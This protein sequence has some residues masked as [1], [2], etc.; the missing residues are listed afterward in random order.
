MQMWFGQKPTDQNTDASDRLLNSRVTDFD[1]KESD[2]SV[3]PKC[4]AEVSPQRLVLLGV[5]TRASGKN[6]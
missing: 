5:G 2:V 4:E 1:R 6:Q 3:L